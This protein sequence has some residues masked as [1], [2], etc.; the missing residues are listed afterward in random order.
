V[1]DGKVVL[2]SSALIDPSQARKVIDVTGKWVTPGF[3]DTHTHYDAELIVAPSLSESVRHGV[4]TVL[5]GSCSLS[6]ICSPDEDT[7][8][9]FTGGNRTSREGPADPAAAQILV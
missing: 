7:A 1:R 2:V 4:T 5:V 9:I 6:M 3:L 8:D